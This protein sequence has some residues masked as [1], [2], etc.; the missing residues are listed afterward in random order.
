MTSQHLL[1]IRERLTRTLIDQYRL[2]YCPQSCQHWVETFIGGQGWPDVDLKKGQESG[3]V[4][5]TYLERVLAIAYRVHHASEPQVKSVLSCA[6][7]YW[8]Q[9]NPNNWNWWWN[10]IGKQRLL[11]G[12]AL[13]L[14][15]DIDAKWL[16]RIALDMPKK[17]SMTGANLADLCMVWR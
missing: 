10:Q 1:T 15:D 5:R 4:I 7:Y 17:A 6:L 11:G 2:D 9:V 16:K 12:I 3:E 8:Y 14:D 13:L